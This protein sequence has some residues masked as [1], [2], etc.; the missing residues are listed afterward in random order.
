MSEAKPIVVLCV[1]DDPKAL[2]A[3]RLV[4]STAGYDV[5]TAS[6]GEDALRILHRREVDLVIADAFLPRFTGAEIT[7]AIKN[8]NPKIRVVL[9]TGA[10]ELPSGMLA[11][12]ILIKGRAPSNFLAE[13]AK[14]LAGQPPEEPEPH[15]QK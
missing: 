1:D 6:S 5:L 11:D 13:I 12:L 7:R 3:R 15:N 2:M 8:Y 10:P 14:V 4:L 9:L